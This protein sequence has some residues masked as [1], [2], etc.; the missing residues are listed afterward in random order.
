MRE[1]Q[2]GWLLGLLA[3]TY[4]AAA[5]GSYLTLPSLEN[6]YPALHKPRWTPPNAVFGPVW[7]VLY[8][9]MAIAAWLVRRHAAIRADQRQARDAALGAWL[10]Q[11][12]LNVAWSDAFFHRRSPRLGLAVIALLWGT[13]AATVALAARV[14]RVGA[15]LLVPYLAWTSYAAALNFRI[16]QLNRSA[17]PAV[18][19]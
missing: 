13:I 7:T 9:Q 4:G 3:T 18:P 1:R 15:L 14:T 2:I 11:L 5:L 8:T 19:Q 12:V 10:L 6:W 17:T 16:W